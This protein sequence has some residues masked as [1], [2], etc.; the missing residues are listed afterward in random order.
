MT[1]GT[2]YLIGAGCGPADLITLRGMDRLRR[3]GAVVYD[4]LI[5]PALLDLAPAGAEKLCMGKR[6]GRPSPSQAEIDAVLISLARAGKDVARLKG[7]DP[8][9]FGRGG[10]EILALREAGVPWEVVPGVTSAVAVPAAAGI[11]VTHRDLS[12]SFH[13]VAGHTAGTAD[14]LPAGLEHLAALEGTLVF[15]MGLSHLPQIVRRLL[16][17][18]KS[19]D[20]PAAVVSW[21]A[22]RPAAVRGPL[23]QIVRLAAGICPPAV[24]VVGET[25][26]LE[27]S[28]PPGPLDGA[29]V[30]LTGTEHIQRKLLD[31]LTALGARAVSVERSLVE[32][33]PPPFDLAK[34][35][36]GQ[37]RWIVLTSANGARLFFRRL[38]EASLDLR[39]LHR[40][41]FAVIG[42]ATGSVLAGWGVQPDLCPGEH[43]SRG[44]GLALREEVRPGEEVLLLRSDQGSPL[45]PALLAEKGLTVWDAPLYRLRPDPET[46]RRG[47]ELL[48]RLD[49]LVF[50][51]AGGVDAFFQQYAALPPQ[52]VCAA[53][54]P[55]TAQALAARGVSPL[56]AEEISAE[57][58]VR[59]I[60]EHQRAIG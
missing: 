51:S 55:V 25:A 20:T 37:P 28:P 48:P 1:T 2:V 49:Y 57:G 40:C 30:G 42:P 5:D 9:V 4:D 60:L 10:E 59:A 31:R 14:G 3:C 26:G 8:F 58:V 56:L 16:E 36:D 33:L 19:P 38:L 29:L 11:P 52:A 53:I 7:G 41:R 54:G 22:S 35:A 18:G 21:D 34:L 39:R 23:S 47:A 46:A 17:A 12:R 44:L 43:T 13:V 45:L 32:E 27:L 24:I 15:L 50:A 6:Q